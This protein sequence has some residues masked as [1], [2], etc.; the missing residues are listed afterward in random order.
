MVQFFLTS[1]FDKISFELD[2]MITSKSIIIYVTIIYSEIGKSKS[3]SK[4]KGYF[5]PPTSQITNQK[6]DLPT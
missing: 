5:F 3:K 1:N 4:S 2:L 6:R